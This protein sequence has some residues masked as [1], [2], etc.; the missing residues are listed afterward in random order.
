MI[1]NCLKICSDPHGHYLV[2]LVMTKCPKNRLVQPNINVDVS[3]GT[4]RSAIDRGYFSQV[5][6][7]S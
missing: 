1:W 5:R 2:K 6:F 4:K 3:G 7:G